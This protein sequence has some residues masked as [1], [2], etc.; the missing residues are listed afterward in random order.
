MLLRK[1]H[2][3][4]QKDRQTDVLLFRCASKRLNVS[5]KSFQ[6]DSFIISVFR[7]DRRYELTTFIRQNDRLKYFRRD[8]HEQ[9]QATVEYTHI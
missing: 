4:R 7:T 3:E 8:H 9:Q 5:L 1:M 6:P 2:C